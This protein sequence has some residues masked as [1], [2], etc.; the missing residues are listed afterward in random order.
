MDKLKIY[1]QK[2]GLT[3]KQVATRL[4][5][6]ESSVCLHENGQRTPNVE[7]LKKYAQ[8]FHCSVDDLLKDDET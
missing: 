1:R 6:T 3:M 5:I 4:D 8:L 2:M 7:M